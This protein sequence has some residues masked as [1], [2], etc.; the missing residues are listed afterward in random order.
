MPRGLVRS[1][2][3]NAGNPIPPSDPAFNSNPVTW[4]PSP[5]HFG[6]PVTQGN[7]PTQFGNPVTWPT[8]DPAHF[9]NIIGSSITS[10]ILL[11]N[12]ID[13]FELEDSSGV[14]LLET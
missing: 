13:F 1:G 2:N 7:S 4:T 6:N 12:G 3:F 14:I 5:T 11:E 9:G 10:G 8:P